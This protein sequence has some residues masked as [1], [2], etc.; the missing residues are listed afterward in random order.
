MAT[1]LADVIVIQIPG[2]SNSLSK[3]S[4]IEDQIPLEIISVDGKEVGK[5]V[6]K[7]LSIIASSCPKVIL[8]LGY[9]P[10]AC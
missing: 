1:S 3:E 2:K 5:P 6:L 4:Q 10:C 8:K 7:V 9:T